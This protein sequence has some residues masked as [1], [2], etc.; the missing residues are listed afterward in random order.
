M[1]SESEWLCEHPNVLTCTLATP[2]TVDLAPG[3]EDPRISGTSSPSSSMSSSLSSSSSSASVTRARCPTP[4][5]LVPPPPATA[6]DRLALARTFTTGGRSRVT[7]TPSAVSAPPMSSRSSRSSSWTTGAVDVDGAV[8]VVGTS[9]RR[10][11]MDGKQKNFLQSRC[12][13]SARGTAQRSPTKTKS[14]NVKCFQSQSFQ[15][16]SRRLLFRDLSSA[17]SDRYPREFNRY[18]KHGVVLMPNYCPRGRG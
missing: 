11:W 16:G 7:R 1:N 3:L 15:S 14:F 12:P 6:L 2:G 13:L 10:R 18:F 8:I 9:L 17:L 4:S 5:V